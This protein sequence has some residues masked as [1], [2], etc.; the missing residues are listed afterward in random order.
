MRWQCAT[1]RPTSA[2]G[3]PLRGDTLFGQ[4]CWALRHRLGD[5]ALDA[6]LDGYVNQRPFLVVSDAF[7]VGHLPRPELPPAPGA[8]PLTRKRERNRRF[9]PLAA[10]AL[11]LERAL[12]QACEQAAFRPA[13]QP[14]NSISRQTFTTGNGFDPFQ[15]ERLWPDKG[16]RL[17][18]HLVVDDGRLSLDA[19][20]QALEDVGRF[21]YGRDASIGLGCYAVEAWREGRP[22]SAAGADSWLALAPVASQGG[23]WNAARCFFRPFTRFGRH[24]ADAATGRNVFKAPVLMADTGAVLTPAAPLGGA[25]FAGQGLGGDGR[26]SRQEPRTVHQGYAPVLPVALG[27][28]A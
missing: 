15:M 10:Y 21:G 11:T 4:L 23:P 6:L 17:D 13:L 19:L 20:R 9:I 24:G 18:I 3:T 8:D 28:L 16:L 7:P 14:H 2:F 5:A 1:L 22:A 26:L 12:E 27:T 25:L